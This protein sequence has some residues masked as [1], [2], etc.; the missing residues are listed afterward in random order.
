[1]KR[2]ITFGFALL[3]IGVLA[4]C[5]SI[6][7]KD[8][9][10]T[11]NDFQV[12]RYDHRTSEVSCDRISAFGL[13]VRDGDDDYVTNNDFGECLN[14]LFIKDGGTYYN[15]TEALN[16]DL[17]TIADVLDV[18]WEFDVYETH[19]LL[20]YT[21]VDYLV[22]KATDAVTY[23]D[24]DSIERVLNISESVYQKFLLGYSPSTMDLLG[25]I[26]VYHDEILIVTLDV[27]QQG[28]FDPT[29]DGFQ[30]SNSSELH[31]LFVSL[32]N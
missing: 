8:T 17:F 25:H 6:H 1:M 32:V 15:L 30:E 21:D 10:Y 12:Y 22:F 2:F 20:D 31:G 27:Y 28:I 9:I 7:Y 5:T 19:V 16:L 26:E 4:S 23:D 24:A 11:I 29:T 13:F 3:F 14:T 18:D